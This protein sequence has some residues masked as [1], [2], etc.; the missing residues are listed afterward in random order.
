MNS[1]I[2]LLSWTATRKG[3]RLGFAKKIKL[4]P[5]TFPH[6][7]MHGRSPSSPSL[8]P[9]WSKSRRIEDL[10]VSFLHVLLFLFLIFD[11][12]CLLL[13]CA[14]WRFPTYSFSPMYIYPLRRL[15]IGVAEVCVKLWH[16]RS[17]SSRVYM[18]VKDCRNQLLPCSCVAEITIDCNSIL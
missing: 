10:V 12:W 8:F 4:T 13:L 17:Q 6:D 7:C 14:F 18:T 5:V 2:A 1:E 11:C 16:C 15:P 9:L 3:F